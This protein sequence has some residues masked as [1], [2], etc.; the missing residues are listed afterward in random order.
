MSKGT[1][2]LKLPLS[3]KEAATR[4]AGED[5]VSLNHWIAAVA[6]KVGA[7]ESAESFLCRRAASAAGTRL[8]DF[9]VRV[10]DIPPQVGDEVV[11]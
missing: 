3:V 8:R 1:Y 6:Q 9:L 11:E 2:P 7:V 10:P 4:L 5:G